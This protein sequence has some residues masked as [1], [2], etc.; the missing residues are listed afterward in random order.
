MSDL[1]SVREKVAEGA[2]WRGTIRVEI[3]GEENELTVRQLR[4]PEFFEVMSLIDRDELQNLR[5]DLP[6]GMMEEYR[7]LQQAEDLDEEEHERLEE[8]RAELEEH[9]DAGSLFES[10]SHDTFEGIRKCAKYAVEP[11]EEDLQHAFRE[12]ASE[13]ER[14][15]GIRV[16]TP[17]DVEPALQDDIEEMIDACTKFTSFTI[18][19]QA[20]V[21]TVG[22]DE[23]NL[24]S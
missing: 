18:G 20:L 8:L 6:D 10:L 17:E 21:Q 14:E 7:E 11:D 1:N 3:G 16:Q 12:R 4:D 24:E 23:G 2:A 13:I 19:I 15:Y 5:E 22:E 9:S